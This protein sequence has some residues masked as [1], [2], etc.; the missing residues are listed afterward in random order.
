MLLLQKKLNRDQKIKFFL[1]V[2]VKDAAQN[3]CAE[4]SKNRGH[5]TATTSKLH[6]SFSTALK[7]HFNE[8]MII[9]VRCF[10]CGKVIGNKWETYL[11]LLQADFSEG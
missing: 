5:I 1:L 11:S 3:Q 9:P 6:F 8:R 7:E 2:F 4:T 10:T